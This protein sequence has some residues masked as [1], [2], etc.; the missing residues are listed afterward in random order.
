MTTKPGDDRVQNYFYDGWTSNH[1]ISTFFAFAPDGTIRACVLD[2]HQSLYDST[3]ADFGGLYTLLTDFYD[4]NRGKV[5]M[6]SSFASADYNF[7]TNSGQEIQFDL[8]VNVDR[9]NL[10][11][12]SAQQYTEWRMH[13][14]Q[15]SF[16]QLHDRFRYK[17][18]GE[19]KT[20]LLTIV[21]LY[22]FRANKAGL[23]QILNTYMPALSKDAN[24]YLCQINE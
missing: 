9:Q 4:S 2:A 1:Y 6:D 15:V 16:P 19:K 7:I 22:N 3:V 17:E 21:L 18:I 12:T 8:G 11:A 24:Y 5:V 10:Q 23:N 14:L 20:M 13:V